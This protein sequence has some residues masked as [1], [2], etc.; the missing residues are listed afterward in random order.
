MACIIEQR[1]MKRGRRRVGFKREGSE[2]DLIK[3]SRVYSCKVEKNHLDYGP[4]GPETAVMVSCAPPYRNR[5]TDSKGSLPNNNSSNVFSLRLQ[6]PKIVTDN[7]RGVEAS[8][9]MYPIH[10]KTRSN[11]PPSDPSKMI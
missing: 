10:H 5:R 8:E 1:G 7:A 2:R 3:S 11:P 4:R 9:N 6:M